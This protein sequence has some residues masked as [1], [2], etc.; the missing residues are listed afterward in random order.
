MRASEQ[1]IFWI[2]AV[3]GGSVDAKGTGLAD[4]SGAIN[5]G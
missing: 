4:L 5:R 3:E 1:A 2:R